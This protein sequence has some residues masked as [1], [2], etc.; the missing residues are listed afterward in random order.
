LISKKM[1]TGCACRK[2]PPP[3]R[4][5][6]RTRPQ[7]R[8]RVMGRGPPLI[9]GNPRPHP[10]GL[11]GWPWNQP[12]RWVRSCPS[13]GRWWR[14]QQAPRRCRWAQWRCPPAIEEEES[15]VLQ[16]EVNSASSCTPSISRHNRSSPP[17]IALSGRRQPSPTLRPSWRSS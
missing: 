14:C 8:R 5:C 11:R 13:P 2:V 15:G 12:S 10:H 7:T 16:L 17:F 4:W 6:L 1:I 9:A 3:P